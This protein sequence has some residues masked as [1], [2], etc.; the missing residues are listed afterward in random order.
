M[1]NNFDGKYMYLVYFYTALIGSGKD[2]AMGLQPLLFLRVIHRVLIFYHGI[3]SKLAPPSSSA[4]D[5]ALSS[6]YTRWLSLDRC[7]SIEELA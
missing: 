1:F 6:S 4:T 5:C 7:Y 2:G 3:F